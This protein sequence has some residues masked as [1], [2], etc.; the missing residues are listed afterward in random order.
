MTNDVCTT[1]HEY[2]IHVL[3]YFDKT[4]AKKAK[5][6]IHM[7]TNA[8]R[9]PAYKMINRCSSRLKN[10]R[11]DT[12]QVFDAHIKFHWFRW[13]ILRKKQ[14]VHAYVHKF[15]YVKKYVHIY[16]H[17]YVHMQ[18]IVLPVVD[19][20]NRD[21]RGFMTYWALSFYCIWALNKWNTIKLIKLC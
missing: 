9:L 14:K 5:K 7:Y 6:R 21:K 18:T 3:F 10:D 13:N 4:V 19:F 12:G 16:T 8:S 17:T 2:N 20:V 1:T 15:I 11:H